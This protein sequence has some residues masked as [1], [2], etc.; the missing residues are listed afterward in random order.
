M[1]D[2][3]KQLGKLL[4]QGAVSGALIFWLVSNRDLRQQLEPALAHAD[5]VWLIAAFLVYGAV[6]FLGAIRWQLFLRAFGFRLSWWDATRI[7][8]IGIFF[9]TLLPGLIA[10]DALRAMYLSKRFAGK[11]ADAVLVVFVERLFGL[12]GLIVAGASMILWRYRWL[13]LS[14][15]TGHLTDLTLV[16][17]GI[18]LVAAVVCLLARQRLSPTRARNY[19]LGS[20]VLLVALLTTV[21]A[22]LCYAGS[23]YCSGEAFASYGPTASCLDMLAITPIVNTFTSLP[24]SFSGIGVRESLLQVFLNDLCGV[25]I[26]VAV[27]IGS[28]G[29]VIRALWAVLGCVFLASCHRLQWREW[30]EQLLGHR[31]THPAQ[32][33]DHAAFGELCRQR[34]SARSIREST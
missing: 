4:L 19:R 3:V 16:V 26:G 10:G 30:T 31:E 28:L 18:G 11:A 12:I 24:I 7:L 20:G 14:A 15:I 27:L 25:P 6:E 32:A 29:F 33:S 5:W 9:N 17:V 21:A 2:R 34:G 22:H 13:H 8:L 1:R 23:F